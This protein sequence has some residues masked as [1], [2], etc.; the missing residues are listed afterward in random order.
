MKIVQHCFNLSDGAEVCVC[1]MTRQNPQNDN[2]NPQKKFKKTN[3]K[4]KIFLQNYI[5]ILFKI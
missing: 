1:T 3:Y 4:H 2:E 5:G